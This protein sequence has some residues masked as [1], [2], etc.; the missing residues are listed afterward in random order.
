MAVRS[1]L[2]KLAEWLAKGQQAIFTD[3]DINPTKG[4]GQWLFSQPQ[5]SRWITN[6]G[7]DILWCFGK[8]GKAELAPI[9]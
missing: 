8:A 1:N 4:T 5:W 2:D 6:H 7:G 9:R 3:H